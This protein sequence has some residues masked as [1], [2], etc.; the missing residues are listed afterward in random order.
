MTSAAFD[1]LGIGNAIVDV[2]T[3]ADDAFLGQHGLVKGSM[4][5]IDEARAETLYAAMGP[6][7]EVSGGSC[8]N[9][10]AGIASFGGKGAYI[11]KVRNDQL[12]EVFGHDLKAIGVSFETASATAGPATARCLIMVTPDAQRTM[13]TYLG[14][15]TGLG[16]DD[17]DTR[18][19][20]SAQVTYV[21]GYLWD[22][23]EAKKAVLKA[24]DAA[25][26][27]GPAGLDHAVG[28]LLRPS[29][30]RG[31]PRPHP[32]QGRYPVRQRGRDQGALRG[33]DLRGG[34]R[35]HA[36]GRQDRGPDPQREGFGG[37]QG[38]RDPCRSRDARR[39]GRR[40]DGRRR[41]LRLGLPVRPYPRQAARRMRAAGRHRRGRG[42]LPCRRAARAAAAQAD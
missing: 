35:S 4:M 17:I 9:T 5:L 15:C 3:R 24:F 8:G 28:F 31:V 2:I 14:A 16:P 25:H 6:G 32:Q 12:G 41:S 11:G 29:L 21:E 27:A 33:R 18:L 36:Q 23:P 7:V 34:P 37:R 42:H 19:V 39:Q 13:N 38:Q 30:S 40:H 22:A 10:M 26:A 1:V 20:G